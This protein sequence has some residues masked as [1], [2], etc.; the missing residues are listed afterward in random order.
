MCVSMCMCVVTTPLQASLQV[1]PVKLMTN[2]FGE[3]RTADRE[4]DKEKVSVCKRENITRDPRREEKQQS[5]L[6][7][8]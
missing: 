2:V 4:R 3:Q 7:L 5:K 6:Y 1:K 8:I